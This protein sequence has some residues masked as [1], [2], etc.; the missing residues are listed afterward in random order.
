MTMTENEASLI[1]RLQCAL[2]M[3]G[4]H[5]TMH[6]EEQRDTDVRL[7][8]EA[9]AVAWPVLEAWERR[10]L[11]YWGPSDPNHW[12][13]YARRGERQAPG[14]VCVSGA[15][16]FRAIHG[17]D[18]PEDPL[19]GLIREGD[20]RM[21]LVQDLIEGDGPRID[22][23]AELL[24]AMGPMTPEDRITYLGSRCPG[25]AH[26]KHEG[27]PCGVPVPTARGRVC[28]CDRSMIGS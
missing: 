19:P 26:D 3:E 11:S 20:P 4:I 28:R 12:T 27:A 15:E 24:D 9:V 8:R 22:R 1:A 7:I 21:N 5:H 23:A 14:T 2:I 17:T 10:T 6:T 16:A 13:A 18:R 25:C